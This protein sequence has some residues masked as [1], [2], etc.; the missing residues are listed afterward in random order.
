MAV[1]NHGSTVANENA[2]DRGFRE[3]TCE[4]VVIARYHREFAALGLGEEEIFGG[5]RSSPGRSER[6][7]ACC[8]RII[9]IARHSLG[10]CQSLIKSPDLHAA[11]SGGVIP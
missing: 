1:H 3:D 11:Q 8:R 7:P 9:T 5:H 2:V 4:G 10:T 6:P